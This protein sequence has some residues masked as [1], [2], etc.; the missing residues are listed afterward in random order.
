MPLPFPDE[1]SIK[2]ETRVQWAESSVYE[3][4]MSSAKTFA[5]AWNGQHP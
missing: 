5:S 4:I 3:R 2:Y 1:S